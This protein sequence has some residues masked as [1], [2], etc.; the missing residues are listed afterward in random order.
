MPGHTRLSS[1][2][3]M[4][5]IDALEQARRQH[6]LPTTIRVDQGSQFT[7]KEARCRPMRT[8][9]RWT[10]A[11]HCVPTS[12]RVVFYDERLDGE[13]CEMTPLQAMLFSWFHEEMLPALL[14]N[15]DRASMAPGVETRMPFM[16]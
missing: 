13:T 7:S 15:F 2:T 11:A 16:D 12:V 3:A 4:E 5:V 1:A 14:R 9:S 6:G 8:A 10:S